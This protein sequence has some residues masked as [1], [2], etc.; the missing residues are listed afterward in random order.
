ML[1]YVI[2]AYNT[3]FHSAVR[4]TPF[5]L[6]FGRDPPGPL[7]PESDVIGSPGEYTKLRLSALQEAR[8]IAKQHLAERQSKS[9][10]L[11]DRNA[12]DREYAIGDLVMAKVQKIPRNAHLKLYPQYVGP[13]R[14]HEIKGASL[15]VTPLSRPAVL[16]KML[17]QDNVRLCTAPPQQNFTEEQLLLP[18]QDPAMT[19]PNLEAESQE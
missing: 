12:K 2:Y 17:H 14:V 10:E 5:Y 6:M 8:R 7:P 11:Y 1:P 13:Y 4:N 19:D 15:S 18:F 16:P 3:E 9:K